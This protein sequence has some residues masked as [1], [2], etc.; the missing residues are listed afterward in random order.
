MKNFKNTLKKGIFSFLIYKK[1]NTF[2]GICRET[3]YVE[4]G[5][6]ENEV[7]NKLTNGTKAILKAIKN[8]PKLLPSINN[9]PPLKYRL[10]FY[11]IPFYY[12]LLNIIK[13]YKVET[14]ELTQTELSAS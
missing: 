3:G 14:F 2:Y 1:N 13:T 8:N 10:L 7:F 4:E 11:W 9:R 5:N 12:S 6:S